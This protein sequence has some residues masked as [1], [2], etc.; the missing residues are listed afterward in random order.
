[1]AISEIADF[2]HH[3][4]LSS[5]DRHRLYEALREC[6]LGHSDKHGGFHLV[7]RYADVEE[8]CLDWRT[9]ASG[10]G[11]FLP[12][13]TPGVRTVSL[14]QDPPAHTATRLLYGQMLSRR[15]VDAALPTIRA[16]ARKYLEELAAEPVGDFVEG[17][18]ARVPVEAIALMVGFGEETSIRIRELA[19]HH[20]LRLAGRSAE[21]PSGSQTLGDAFTAELADR[22]ASPRDD[23]LTELLDAELDGV[24]VDDRFRVGFLTGSLV[25][26]HETTMAASAYLAL[27]LANDQKLQDGIAAD[28]DLLPGA[29]DESL[30][31]RSP[32]PN[33]ARTALSDAT[34]AGCPVARGDKVMLLFGSANRDPRRWTDPTVF[35]PERSAAG[36]L[37]FGWGIHRCIGASFAKAELVAIFDE[38][39]SFR[40]TPAGQA[41]E[42]APSAGGA[43]QGLDSLPVRLEHRRA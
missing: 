23:F 5:V 37:A 42:A 12:D 38:L 3:D 10:H 1:M 15:R 28:P 4:Q 7:A 43:F 29:I 34:I 13:L 25:A 2:D 8:V 27:E 11:V 16:R 36:H 19:E 22:R 30:R 26:G 24:P 20:W 39:R 14:E 40:M 9:F 35:D 41:R 31:H 18:S 6:P 32:V 33:M 17:V 21:V